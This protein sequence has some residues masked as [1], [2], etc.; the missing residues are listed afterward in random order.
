MLGCCRSV[1]S[2]ERINKIGEGTYGVVYQARDKKSNEIVAL[3]KVRMERET[4][5]I[6]I[7]AL[8]EISILQKLKHPNIV[9]L[10]EVVVGDKPDS[11]FLVFEYVE[12]DLADLVDSMRTGGFSESEVKCI[13]IQL[14][15]AVSH[16]HDNWILHRDLKL[17]NLLF[18][19][20]GQLKL[21]D[22][23]LARLF[24]YPLRPYTPKVATLWYRAPEL[25]L[26]AKNYSTAIDMWA[27]G[28][29]M[30]E[31]LH[32]APIMPGK[33]EIEQ[34]SFIFGL[35]GTAND[36]IWPGFSQLPNAKRVAH[37][38]QPYVATK[39][40]TKLNYE[41]EIKKIKIKIT[42]IVISS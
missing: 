25:L 42:I 11:M 2:F 40:K 38:H 31:L 39:K 21:A 22:F 30:A 4:D 6:P 28:C 35:L 1:S 17:S 16:L 8:R 27:V 19:N 5:G 12:H 37:I 33:T 36:K 34:I 7:T 14:L 24:G 15:R 10:M 9:H 26:G 23:G 3:K 29:I 32:K 18:N 13:I 20:K 41:S